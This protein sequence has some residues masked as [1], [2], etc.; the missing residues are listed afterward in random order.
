[1]KRRFVPDELVAAESRRLHAGPCPVCKG[2][3]PVDLYRSHWVQSMLIFTRHGT[4]AALCCRPCHNK[5]WL[6][7]TA[8]TVS[9][10]WWGVP[11]GVILTP[12]QLARNA[13]EFYLGPRPGAPSKRMHT[14]VQARLEQA[15][16]K[17]LESMT[18]QTCPH[19]GALYKVKDYDPE[20]ARMAC[21]SCN[22]D[23]P[24]PARTATSTAQPG[25]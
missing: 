3:G 9:M 22:G 13:W 2:P 18:S 11:H 6:K 21:R 17:A 4:H 10:G 23:L 24:R 7:D 19:C 1:M 15:A 25:G 8:T 20:A 12:V 14:F 5:T 16:T